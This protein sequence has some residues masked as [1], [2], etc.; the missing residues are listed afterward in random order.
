ML[1][2]FQHGEV[3]EIRLAR[4]L[5]NALNQALVMELTNRLR[6]AAHEGARALVLSGQP[7]MFSG[8]LDVPMLITLD[9]NELQ[10]FM[11]SVLNLQHQLAVQ[12]IPIV[13]AITG[14]CAA[15]ATVM[16]AF[17]DYRVMT[18]GNYKI[19]LNE[20]AVGLC[21]GKIAYQSFRRLVG[22]RYADQLVVRGEF[23]DPA[24]ALRIG[25]VE[26]VVAAEQVIPAAIA[27]AQAFVALPPQAM[28]ETR[29]IARHDLV[30]LCEEAMRDDSELLH[31]R[32]FDD[33]AQQGLHA[34]ALK[35]ASDTPR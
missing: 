13:A 30:L 18:A 20:V 21:P 10:R 4:P 35:L 12:P 14:H 32:W 7:G 3:R 9:W 19:G 11:R 27:Y 8:G 34:L 31:K 16:A 2:E 6:A 23:I 22:A 28:L 24:E 29:R 15:A 25:L 17:C 1:E 26:Q 33:E 5:A